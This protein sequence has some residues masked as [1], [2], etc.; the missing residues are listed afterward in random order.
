[1]VQRIPGPDGRVETGTVAEPTT[2]RDPSRT[3]SAGRTILQVDHV[4]K[5]FDARADST[6]AIH[7]LHFHI[8]DQEF[9]SLCG[10]SGCGKTTLLKIIA[11]LLTPTSGWVRLRDQT[12][13]GPPPGMAVVFQDYSRSLMPWMTIRENVRLPLRRKRLPRHSQNDLIQRSLSDVD[14]AGFGGH[15]PWQLSGGMQQRVAIARALAY[16]PKILLLDEPFGSVDAQTRSELQDLIL[17]VRQEY[18]VTLL[19]V[20]HDVDE[21]VYVSDRVVVLSPRPAR[22]VEIISV[23]LP[24][25]RDQVA[26]KRLPRFI[27]LRSRV[28]ELI[29]SDK[30]SGSA[31]S[32]GVS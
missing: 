10:P 6:E 16:Q 22:I 3:A 9:V 23:D 14:L 31:P 18:A 13:D 21:A 5:V 28:F 4:S 19:L 27:E 8:D 25:Q 24:P 30:S 11:G 7:D 17:R 32:T 26:T 20:T 1:M 15:Y 12:V 29:R 2:S